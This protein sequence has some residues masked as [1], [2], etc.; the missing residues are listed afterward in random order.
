LGGFFLVLKYDACKTA[1]YKKI[2][3]KAYETATAFNVLQLR[4]RFGFNRRL[5]ALPPQHWSLALSRQSR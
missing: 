4:G 3:K 1:V 2:K 5:N